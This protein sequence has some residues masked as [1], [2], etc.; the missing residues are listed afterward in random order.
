MKKLILALM[1]AISTVSFAQSTDKDDVDIVQAVY[2]KEKTELVSKFM[3]LTGTQ[4]DAFAKVYDEYEVERKLLGQKKIQ[5]IKDYAANY[6]NLT[7]SSADKLAKES[8]DNNLAY[9]KL[10]A[11]Y[12]DKS[13]KAIGAI[14]AA[15]FIQ[16]E[17][18][19]QTV[20]RMEIQTAVPFIGEMHATIPSTK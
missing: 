17:V 12:Y 16:L 7:D 9:D 18:Y 20:I 4:A 14:N 10:Y 15:K 19:L 11:K 13:K 2:G 1:L 6:E 8:L 5:I 3:A